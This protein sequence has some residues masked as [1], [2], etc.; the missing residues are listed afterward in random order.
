MQV[1]EDYPHSANFLSIASVIKPS[2]ED[3]EVAKASLKSLAGLLPSDII[4]EENPDLIYFAANGA[5]AGVCNENDDCLDPATALEIYHLSKNKYINV[6][7]KRD[8]VVGSVLYPGLSKY[9]ENVLINKEDALKE[10]YFNLSLVAIMWKAI[11]KKL[12]DVLS[13]AG[14]E[15]SSEFGKISLSWEVFFKGY[16]IAIGSPILADARIVLNGT[17][18][19]EK[20]LPYLKHNKGVGQYQGEKVYRVIRNT[21]DSKNV[22]IGGYS[23]VTN[24]AAQVEGI[25]SIL[26]N[27]DYQ[28][29]D[30]RVAQKNSEEEK[31]KEK[32][33]I[34]ENSDSQCQKPFV[35]PNIAQ[36]DTVTQTHSTLTIKKFMDIKKVEDITSNWGEFSK[37]EESVAS[38]KISEIW[39]NGIKE[40]SD[41]FVAEISAKDAAVAEAQA[42]ASTAMKEIEALKASYQKT[43]DELEAMKLMAKSKMDQECYSARMCEMEDEYDLE[44]EDRKTLASE[45][46]GMDDEMYAGYKTKFASLAKYKSKKYKAQMEE[47]MRAKVMKEMKDKEAAASASVSTASKKTTEEIAQEALASASAAPGFVPAAH[48]DTQV[49]VLDKYASAFGKDAVKISYSKR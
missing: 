34:S 22:I 23:L 27:S 3:C 7:H 25:L 31:N 44:D 42:Q 32:N 28:V 24:P 19:Y 12:A 8:I 4:P 6:D 10:K 1:L 49:S 30:P 38:S 45:I 5:V 16:D 11:N 14:D 15:S 13:E 9:K 18:E 37:L 41:K 43:V 35:I 39:K 2:D 40:A 36:A 20:L 48:V 29:N 26:H 21:S 33:T 17:E 46:M 47:E